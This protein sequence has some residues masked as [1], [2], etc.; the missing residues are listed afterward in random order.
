MKRNFNSAKLKKLH[1]LSSK[2][3]QCIKGG[4]KS[5]KRKKP[6]NDSNSCP[7]DFG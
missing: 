5:G 7:P 3:L 6:G 1:Q 2:E 4:K